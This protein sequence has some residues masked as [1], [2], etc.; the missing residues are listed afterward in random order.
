MRV[1]ITGGKGQL[2]RALAAACDRDGNEVFRLSKEELDVT[3]ADA[4]DIGIGKR[5]PHWVF[6]TGAATKVDRCETERA[7]AEKLNRDAAGYVAT[8]CQKYGAGM[9]HYS[10]DFVF[11]GTKGAPYVET[12]EPNPL[13][14][15]GAT[16]LAGEKAVLEASPWAYFIVRTQWVFGAGGRNFPAAILA[17]AR[18]GEDLTV[19]DDQVGSPT[20]TDDIAQATLDLVDLHTCGGAEPGIY[21]VA[22]AGV[23][24]WFEFAEKLLA[25]SGLNSVSLAPIKSEVLHQPASRPA[26]SVL[27]TGKL[28]TVRGRAM[29]DVDDAIARYLQ[30]E[31]F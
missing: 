19:V 1:L 3:D 13:S 26:Y 10:T 17:K 6:H 11:D 21:H 31:R 25:A 5:R 2:A 30:Q 12:D 4:V 23:L 15:Y 18:R 20:L 14:V 7:W 27:D 29:P 28:D 9:V 16:K 24:S 22:N 8:S